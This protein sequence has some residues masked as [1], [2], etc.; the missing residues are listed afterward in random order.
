MSEEGEKDK[1]LHLEFSDP[2]RNPTELMGSE[3]SMRRLF[4]VQFSCPLCG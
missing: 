3:A 2:F 4:L 1:G